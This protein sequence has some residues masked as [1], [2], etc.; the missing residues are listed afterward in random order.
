MCYASPA[1]CNFKILITETCNWVM[2]DVSRTTLSWPLSQNMCLCNFDAV[3]ILKKHC[4]RKVHITV[5][6]TI[7]NEFL[8]VNLF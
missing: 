8:E 5:E 3:T 1:S 7:R 4:L 2:S 6:C